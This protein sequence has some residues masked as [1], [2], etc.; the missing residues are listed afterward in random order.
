MIWRCV[1]LTILIG[2]AFCVL[3]FVLIGLGVGFAV[4]EARGGLIKMFRA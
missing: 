1:G 2:L 4:G 3:P